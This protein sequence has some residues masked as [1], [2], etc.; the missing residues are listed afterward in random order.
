MRKTTACS[1]V[2]I[3]LLL[4]AW[5]GLI[6]LAHK[7]IGW[8]TIWELAAVAAMGLPIAGY[9]VQYLISPV[10]NHLITNRLPK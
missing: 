7:I 1:I 6:V 10:V 8:R 5:V 3:F 2:N 9:F 4:A